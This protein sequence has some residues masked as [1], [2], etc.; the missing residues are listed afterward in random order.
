MGWIGLIAEPDLGDP[1]LVIPLILSGVGISMAIIAAQSSAGGSV[2]TA[3]ASGA[4]TI[5]RELGGVF[6]IAIAVAV[7]AAAGRFASPAAF[8][9][10]MGA[11][12]VIVGLRRQAQQQAA[13]TPV[14]AVET[15]GRP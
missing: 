6:G 8:A 11:A 7:F 2:V 12:A 1:E 10:V 5:M 9:A 4:K 15:E 3:R 13:T 14:P